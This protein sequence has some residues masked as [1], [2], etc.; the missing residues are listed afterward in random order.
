MVT[1]YV[2]HRDGGEISAIIRVVK[3]V[4][5]DPGR[6]KN[7]TLRVSAGGGWVGGQGYPVSDHAFPSNIIHYQTG[8]ET[9]RNTKKIHCA[10]TVLSSSG[11]EWQC[12]SL[13]DD[14]RHGCRGCSISMAAV[15]GTTL[16]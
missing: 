6:N 14:G 10:S 15:I 4:W 7:Y 11:S 1:R 12:F 3:Y 13:A 16:R 2:L 8:E 5:A 9:S